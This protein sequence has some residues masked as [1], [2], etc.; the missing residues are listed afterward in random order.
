MVVGKFGDAHNPTKHSSLFTSL[1]SPVL[2][3]DNGKITSARGDLATETYKEILLH[4]SS[5]GD[6]ILFHKF[7]SGKILYNMYSYVDTSI[8][9]LPAF[10][11]FCGYYLYQRKLVMIAHLISVF[12]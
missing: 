12:L 2:R 11:F 10:V 4:F 9:G 6:W 7:L 8:T 5:V 1:E 3:D